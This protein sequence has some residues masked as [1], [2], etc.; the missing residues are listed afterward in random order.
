[1][2][3]DEIRFTDTRASVLLDAVRGGAA[4]CVLLEHWR[5]IFFVDY[6]EI[7][8][9]RALWAPLYL[10]VSAGH[11]AVVIFFVLSGYL[12]SGSVFRT[13]EKNRWDW[14][15][16]S[17]HRL[18]RLWIVLLPA[19][20]LTAVFDHAGMHLHRAPA[21]ALYAGTSGDHVI[22]AVRN[23]AGS[24][25][26]LG[27][28]A[29]LQ[30]IWVPTFGSNG[31]LW[32]LTNEFWY[33]VLFPLGLTVLRPGASRWSKWASAVLF[34][35]VAVFLPHGIALGFLIWLLGTLLARVRPPRAGRAA[36]WAATAVYL[37]VFFAFARVPSLRGWWADYAL[38]VVTFG[39]LWVLLSARE[40]SAESSAGTRSARTLARFSY[41]LYA[42][43]LPLLAFLAACLLPMTRWQPAGHM[44]MGV[45]LLLL[46]IGF[47][48][49]VAAVTEFRTDRVRMR[50]ER[51]LR[52]APE[53]PLRAS[54]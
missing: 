11:Q 15:L 35:A 3:H 46:V 16:Y 36:R 43:H 17:V 19:L 37:P 47:A 22:D 26:A 2:R 20:L 34:A 27:N 41:T 44:M 39:F 13:V 4:L 1:M 50:I 18:L 25:T 53:K 30:G 8:A 21:M 48:W 52:R 31:A 6:Q 49:A 42:V 38:G 14:R 5:N 7:V 9:H 32:S 12:I 23:A 28:A 54:T 24:V 10:L 40:P 33:Y 51:T 29:F 45:A